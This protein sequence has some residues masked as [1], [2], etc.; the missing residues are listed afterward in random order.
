MFRTILGSDQINSDEK[1][2]NQQ[3]IACQVLVYKK[4]NMELS[5]IFLAVHPTIVIIHELTRN[6][7][8]QILGED[9]TF[10]WRPIRKENWSIMFEKE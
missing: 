8:F 10:K 2:R 7:A 1:Y 9:S 6:S 3:T 4:K 5:H